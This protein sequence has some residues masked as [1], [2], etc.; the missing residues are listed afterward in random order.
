MQTQ[1]TA[2]RPATCKAT[3]CTKA[4]IQC[5]QENRFRNA[6]HRAKMFQF[7]V[8][9]HAFYMH[10]NIILVSMPR[11][12]NWSIHFKIY[13]QS[14]MSSAYPLCPLNSSSLMSYLH[15]ICSK[16]LFITHLSPSH[17]ASSLLYP[18]IHLLHFKWDSRYVCIPGITGQIEHYHYLVVFAQSPKY[19]IIK[20]CLKKGDT[21][22]VS[23]YR[24]ISLLTG[25]SKIFKLLIYH[26]LKHNLVS[27]NIL[28]NEHFSFHVSVSIES[29]FLNSVSQFLMHGIIKNI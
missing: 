27:N 19:A 14:A 15:S 3:H 10:Y 24:L 9:P 8:S 5:V 28:A 26:R 13:K 25:F 22:Q 29:A 7:M 23:N 20:S 12:P 18:N 4:G 1:Y 6:C 11:P 17:V 16:L 21:S 2:Q